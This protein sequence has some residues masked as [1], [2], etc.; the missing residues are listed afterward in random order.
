MGAESPPSPTRGRRALTALLAMLGALLVGLCLAGSPQQA[1]AASFYDVPSGEW[2]ATWVGQAADKGLMSGYKDARGNLTGWFGP[3]DPITRAQVATVL[4]R[5]AG[6]K[7]ASGASFPD[8]SPSD[9]HYQAVSWCVRAG[10][11]TGYTAGADKGRFRPD[12]AVTRQELAVMVW[13]YARYAGVDVSYP[14]P[15]P[16]KSTSDWRS[17]DSWASEALT[18]TSAA[19]VL[20]GSVNADGTRSVLPLGTATRAQASK[21]FVVLSGRP[22]APKATFTVSFNSNGGSAVKAQSVKAG[23]KASKPANPTR[24][25]YTFKGWYADKGLTEAYDFG[26]KVTAGV[27]LYAKW[28]ANKYTVAFESNGGSAVSKQTV[29]YGAKASKPANPTRAGYA[30]KGWY[31]DKALTKAYDFNAKVTANATLYAKWE[32][33]KYTVTFEPNGGSAVSK[34]TVTYGAKA[35]KPANPTRAGYTFKGWYADKSL[36]KAYDFGAAVKGNLTLYA[37]WEGQPY[38]VLCSDGLLSLQAGTDT[39]DGR[40]SVVAQWDWDGAS[41]PWSSEGVSIRKVVA[42][43]R[44]PVYNAGNLFYN[45]SCC[46]SMDL[47]NLDV[48][49]A[50]SFSS[51]SPA[52]RPSSPSISPAGTCPPRRASPTCSPAARPSSPSIS[53][54]GTSPTRRA[55]PTSSAASPPSRPSTSPAGTRPPRRASPTSSPAARPS[56]PSTSPAGTCPPRRASGTCSPAAR[57]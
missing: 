33:N 38:A 51:M 53:P 1:R 21:V 49:S 55:S 44:V 4:W 18:W 5:M 50:T 22:S 46:Q 39:E 10:I 36:T 17:V 12:R 52:A 14:D 48:S 23:A 40:G 19:G 25:G 24:A 31:A 26:S 42:R 41:R 54:A 30:F 16:F 13:R 15:T 45:L 11:V 57:P 56:L 43:D 6:G 29:S 35:S 7:A 9:W 28:E 47:G 27:T 3:D 20:S 8:V 2:Y 32:A 34:Q 37:K